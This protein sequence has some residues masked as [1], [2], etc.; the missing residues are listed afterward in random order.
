MDSPQQKFFVSDDGKEKLSITKA[1]LQAG[2][3]TGKHS[4]KTLAWTKGMSSW[5]PLSDPSWEKHGITTL[6]DLPPEL[7][8]QTQTEQSTV[9]KQ[10][11]VTKDTVAKSSGRDDQKSSVSSSLSKEGKERIVNLLIKYWG[12]KI[13]EKSQWKSGLIFWSS[14]LLFIFLLIY[15]ATH[16]FDRIAERKDFD[17]N[18]QSQSISTKGS[19]S[20]PIDPRTIFNQIK[21]KHFKKA[22]SNMQNGL[23]T[24]KAILVQEIEELREC[25]KAFDSD[26]GKFYEFELKGREY[27]IDVSYQ[28][29]QIIAKFHKDYSNDIVTLSK[30]SRRELIGLV[31]EWLENSKEA[32]RNTIHVSKWIDKSVKELKLKIPFSELEKIGKTVQIVKDQNRIEANF[33]LSLKELQYYLL[34]ADYKI[35]N[36]QVIFFEDATLE[37]FNQLAI[38]YDAALEKYVNSSPLE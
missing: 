20:S 18:R 16:F 11:S 37:R 24:S 23:V 8:A 19:D 29:R 12:L 30:S 34:E 3:D 31:D 14:T 22:K 13:S 1:E 25:L 10:Q 26:L 35:D 21:L 38:E 7:P 28:R 27:M 33:L 15:F 36:G 9:S 5:L 4:E 32:L 17:K 2:I 6:S